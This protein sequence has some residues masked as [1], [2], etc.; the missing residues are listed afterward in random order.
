M[1]K[2]SPT[3][4]SKKYLQDLGY[5]VVIVERWNPF[6]KIRQDMFGFI[7]LLAIK[8]GETLAVQTTSGSNVSARVE[9]IT[10]HENVDLVRDAGW[11]I[12]VH[13]WRKLKSGWQVRI[14]DLS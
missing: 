7:D 10:N 11:K 13:G 9:K 8:T 1:A 14:V 3:Q 12:H 5:A 4:R 6:A 2:T